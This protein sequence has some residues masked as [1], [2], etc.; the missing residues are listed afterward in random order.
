MAKTFLNL[1][2]LRAS[3][4]AELTGVKI[5]DVDLARFYNEITADMSKSGQKLKKVVTN[6]VANQQNYG[7]SVLPGFVSTAIVKIGGV[8][9]PYIPIEDYVY[10][11]DRAALRHTVVDNSVYLLPVPTTAVTSGLEVWYYAKLPEIIDAAAGATS[12]VDL[13]DK[14]WNVVVA[15][16]TYKMYE[17]LLIISSVG[18]QA[19]P[20]TDVSNI[21]K[22]V[23]YLEKRYNEA[24]EGYRS[25]MQ[26]LHKPT[27]TKGPAAQ[28]NSVPY[29]L[30]RQNK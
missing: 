17:K 2:N 5:L 8:E 15:G 23:T 22:I 29:G 28:E 3:K 20:D 30:G 24:L 1:Q 6:I 19:L 21:I 7:E 14:Q 12:L 10:E 18:S 16:M 25:A 9:A 26:I 4:L 11:S 27:S 13:D